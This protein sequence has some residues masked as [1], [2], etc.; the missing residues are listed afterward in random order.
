[1]QYHYV[2]NDLSTVALYTTNLKHL[3]Y[4][5]TTLNCGLK[6]TSDKK[7]KSFSSYIMS[8]FLHKDIPVKPFLNILLVNHSHMTFTKVQKK[9]KFQY[10]ATLLPEVKSRKLSCDKIYW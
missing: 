2:F 10:Q 5:I 4:C 6:A 3:I 9:G 7:H 1:M 8:F